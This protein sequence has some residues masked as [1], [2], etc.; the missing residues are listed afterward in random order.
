MLDRLRDGGKISDAVIACESHLRG[1]MPS[2]TRLPD[3]F[4]HATGLVDRERP[5]ILSAKNHAVVKAGQVLTVITAAEDIPIND[6]ASAPEGAAV[7]KLPRY[8]L[9]L[10]DTILVLAKGQPEPNKV[11]T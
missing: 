4:G 9:C 8:S 6:A 2:G 7:R 11:L 3:T 5:M 10:S 1:K